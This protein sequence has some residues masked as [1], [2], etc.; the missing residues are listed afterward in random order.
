MTVQSIQQ[1]MLVTV[2]HVWAKHSSDLRRPTFLI[3]APINPV[4]VVG[5]LKV[6]NMV[7]VPLC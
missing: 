1:N 5:S 2:V 6:V 3:I 4:A 7:G